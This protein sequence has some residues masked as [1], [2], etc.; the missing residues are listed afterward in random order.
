MT[1]ERPVKRMQIVG[2]RDRIAQSGERSL[3]NPA[4]RGRLAKE[5]FPA[6]GN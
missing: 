2:S 6:H 1:K 5:D 3:T 4:I